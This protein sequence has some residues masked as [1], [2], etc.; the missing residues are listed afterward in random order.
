MR[1]TLV[2]YSRAMYANWLWHRPLQLLVDAGEGVHLALGSNMFAF[3]MLAMT[4]GHSDHVLGLPGL[5]GARRFG[6][7]A[8]SKAWTVLYP[9][10]SPGV[11]TMRAVLPQLWRGVD[12]PISWIPVAP[13]DARPIGR[14]RVI[15]A[16][17]VRHV[18]PD[19]ALGYRVIETR[20]R[21][22]PEL[23]A[24]PQPE[25]EQIA[26]TRGRE[27]VMEDYRHVIFVHSGD[28]MPIDPDI[29]RGA[30]L[31]VHDATFLDGDERREPIHATS[32]EALAVAREAGVRVLVMSHLSTR[33]D[34]AAAIP[35]L[36]E[37]VVASG[38]EG[39]CWLLDEAE[40]VDLRPEA[41]SRS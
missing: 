3:S 31:L 37:Q 33:Y 1:D 22:K 12:F 21:L 24:L 5:A 23:T 30:D 6:R 25:I 26:R 35:R 11:E 29:A 7:G 15:E 36:S 39:E 14:Q 4:H 8:T 38:F 2:G 18:P 34:R 32:E 10:G 13:G 27:A 20:R 17:A 40:F 28:A 9:A 16:F 19:P 41:W